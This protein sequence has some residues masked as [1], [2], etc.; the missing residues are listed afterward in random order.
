MLMARLPAARLGSDDCSLVD[1]WARV[2]PVSETPSTD[3]A[4]QD[5]ALVDAR[6][7]DRE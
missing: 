7:T 6:V 2:R 5:L 1:A 3:D 4:G